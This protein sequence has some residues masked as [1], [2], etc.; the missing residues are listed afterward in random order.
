MLSL[1][2]ATIIAI[3]V[4]HAHMYIYIYTLYFTYVEFTLLQ[5]TYKNTTYVTHVVDVANVAAWVVQ[6][7]TP[8]CKPT[9]VLPK[10]DYE[11]NDI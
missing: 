5:S 1:F 10:I 6:G 9:S 2:F 3:I 8:T 7:I 11:L 4:L